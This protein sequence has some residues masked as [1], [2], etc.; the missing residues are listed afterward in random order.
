MKM[1]G[2][3][4]PEHHRQ[5][6]RFKSG[7][8]PLVASCVAEATPDL[9]ETTATVV[10]SGDCLDFILEVNHFNQNRDI[11]H[12][13][14]ANEMSEDQI[15]QKFGFVLGNLTVDPRWIPDRDQAADSYNSE[16]HF[17]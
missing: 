4:L 6:R 8:R 15:Y 11:F 7:N 10:A 1:S 9:P 16:W 14:T 17:L 5:F 3:E 13:R 2:N 12:W